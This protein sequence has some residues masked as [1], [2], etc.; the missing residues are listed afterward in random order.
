MNVRIDAGVL[1]R[2]SVPVAVVVGVWTVLSLLGG[3]AAGPALRYAGIVMALGYVFVRSRTL[4]DR[5]E[6]ASLAVT[7]GAVIR[8]NVTPVI[9]AAPWFLAA[10][11]LPV[12]GSAWERLGLPGGFTSP[13]P[14]LQFL[15]AAVG[16]LTVALYV[17]V[18]AR[19]HATA[20]G[21][22]DGGSSSADAVVGDD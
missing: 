14:A 15:A 5:T 18:F 22:N 16:L 8:A 11:L 13:A 7:P 6:H 2:E 20:P 9:G 4:A 3:S 21:D 12:V 10:R 17:A 19:T 1:L